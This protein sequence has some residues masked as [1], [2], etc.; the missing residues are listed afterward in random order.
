MPSASAA[1]CVTSAC[2]AIVVCVPVSVLGAGLEARSVP[3]R[4]CL[5]GVFYQRGWHAATVRRQAHG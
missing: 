2:S 4:F 3:F 5:Y 1:S